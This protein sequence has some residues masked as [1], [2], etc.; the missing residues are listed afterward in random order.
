MGSSLR[1]CQRRALPL[2]AVKM[3]GGTVVTPVLGVMQ[4]SAMGLLLLGSA[5]CVRARAVIHQFRAS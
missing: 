1:A 2:F 4:I 3:T 5:R